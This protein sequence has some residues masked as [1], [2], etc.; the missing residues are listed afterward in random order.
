MANALSRYGKEELPLI[1]KSAFDIADA[2][3]FCRKAAA[4]FASEGRQQQAAHFTGLADALD[5]VLGDN[6]GFQQLLA[7][8]EP[9]D[10]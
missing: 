10:A 8:G 2:S 1:E 6:D 4:H 7:L 5:W 9:P 3:R